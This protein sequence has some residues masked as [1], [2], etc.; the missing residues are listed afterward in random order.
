MANLRPGSQS[1]SDLLSALTFQW[2]TSGLAL[3]LHSDLLSALT[4]QCLI[5]G[6]AL[7]Y[8]DLLAFLTVRWLTSG[9]A[10]SLIVTFWPYSLLSGKPLAWLSVLQ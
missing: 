2:L 3:S 5:S 8:C 10:L 7:S 6:L 9:L 4:F 1:Y